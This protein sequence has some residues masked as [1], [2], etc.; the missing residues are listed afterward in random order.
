VDRHDTLQSLVAGLSAHGERSALVVMHAEGAERWSYGRLSDEVA[1]LARGLAASGVGPGAAVALL[2]KN[3]PEWLVACLAI[4]AAGAAVVPIDSQIGADALAHILRDSNARLIFTT[5]EYLN[6]I[7]RASLERPPRPVLLDVAADD[8][9]GWQALKAEHGPALPS[10]TPDDQAALFYTSGTTGVPKGVPLT[11]RNLSFELSALLDS[12]LVGPSDSA[13]A[14]LPFYHVYPFATMLVPLALGSYLVLPAGMTGPQLVRALK[15]GRPTVLIGVPRLYRALYTGIAG[16]ARGGGKLAAAYFNRGLR[17]SIW[18]RRRT[19][20]QL[21]RTILRPIHQRIGGSLRLMASGGSALDPDIAEKLDGMGWELAIGYGLTETSPLLTINPPNSGK[22]ASAG[23]ALPGVEL[24]VAPLAESSEQSNGA[25]P[26]DPNAPQEGEIQARGPNVFAGYRNLPEATAAA[27]TPDGWFRTGDLGHFDR[28]GFLYVTGRAN[29]LIVT[30]SGKKIQPDPLE[31]I[32]THHPLLQEV[33]VLKAENQLAAVIVPNMEEVNRRANGNVA[34]GVR[35]A[36]AEVLPTL[37][38]HQR[39]T[40]YVISLDQLPKTNL[41]K[42]RR[43]QLRELYAQLKQGNVATGTSTGPV[44]IEDMS[45]QDQALLEQ[46]PARQAW[47][48]FAERYHDRPLTPDT[49]PALDLGID[50]LAWLNLTLEISQRTGVELNDEAIARISTVRDLLREV[51]AEPAEAPQVSALEHPETALTPEELSW[52]RPQGWLM[53]Q[54]NLLLMLLNH[55][56]MRWCFSLQTRG[57]ENVPRAGQ[58]VFTPNHQ[59][60]LDV[61]VI[62]ASLPYSV[63]RRTYWAGSSDTVFVNP[64]WRLFS[65]ITRTV[66]IARYSGTGQKS[67]AMGAAVLK[68]GANLVWF[69][70]GKLSISRELLPFR[71]GLGMVLEQYPATLVPVLVEGTPDALPP[72]N[73]RLRFKPC[74][75]TFG[76]PVT[77]AELIAEGEGATDAARMMDALHGR[78]AALKAE[79]AELSVR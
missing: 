33:G 2:S 29:T 75:V 11:H 28:D 4:F 41:G 77:P 15:E 67:L 74:R 37:P 22:L 13:L 34:V 61:A 23:A 46:E 71:Q 30:E 43:H 54:L 50:S 16:Q 12:G 26:P 24:R 10:V 64:I 35:E 66:P 55:R 56:L 8:A 5:T 51:S 62:A 38:S 60:F 45:E 47:E 72:D 76:K 73:S 63:L 39:V 42:I 18:L 49:S 78:V 57:V 68:G 52:L 14:P 32:Y 6:R 31:E 1:R 53:R 48:L 7:Q 3:R 79:R 70:E 25:A 20:L 19:G 69:P 9:R 27:F 17:L 44:A 59:S 40:D 36:L 58:L 21:G 65:R